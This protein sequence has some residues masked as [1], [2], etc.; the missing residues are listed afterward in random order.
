MAE[1][2]NRLKQ[3]RYERG[4]SQAALAGLVGVT[5]QTI[6]SIENGKNDPSLSLAFACSKVFGLPIEAIFSTA[7]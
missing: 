5:R 6:N 7:G 3:L 1:I 4:L 2:S